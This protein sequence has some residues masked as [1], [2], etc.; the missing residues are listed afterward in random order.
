MATEMV[1]GCKQGPFAIRRCT[2]TGWACSADGS[3]TTKT[4]GKARQHGSN[5]RVHVMITS[6][7]GILEHQERETCQK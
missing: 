3:K 5:T 1:A 7:K 2:G 6:N 4:D